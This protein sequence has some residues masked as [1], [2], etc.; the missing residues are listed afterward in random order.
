MVAY[1][2]FPIPGL[3]FALSLK[4]LKALRAGGG[5]FV[6]CRGGGGNGSG[7]VDLPTAGVAA[8]G[9]LVGLAEAAEFWGGGNG[10]GRCSHRFNTNTFSPLTFS[11]V[12]SSN[13]YTPLL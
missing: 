6:N 5:G 11:P 7:G 1:S 10:S 3:G 4:A 2:R 12:D 13:Q 8:A 9:V